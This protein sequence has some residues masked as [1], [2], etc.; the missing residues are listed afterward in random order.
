M[1]A[2]SQTRRARLVQWM[3]A[4]EDM[5]QPDGSPSPTALHRAT[6]KPVSYCNDLLKNEDKAFG[7]KAARSIEAALGMNEYYLDGIEPPSDVDQPELV[8]RIHQRLS[9]GKGHAVYHDSRESWLAFQ[10]SFLRKVGVS[11][12][13]AAIFDVSGQ[14]MVPELHD[15]AVVLINMNVRNDTIIDGKHYA[16]ILDDDCLVKTLYKLKDGSIKAVSQNP[17]KETYP[18]ITIDGKQKFE[19]LGMVLWEGRTI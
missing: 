3:M 19:L 12:K 14:S 2:T 1:K 5:R 17:D 10:P 9:A 13:S 18:D 4:H 8:R 11:Q 7:E 15:G 16:F 6:G